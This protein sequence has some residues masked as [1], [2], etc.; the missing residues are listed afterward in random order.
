MTIEE[1]LKDYILMKNRSVRE[2]AMKIGM[3][4]S[5]IN[6]IFKRG[7]ENSSVTT[8]I[9]ICRGLGISTDELAEGRITPVGLPSLDPVKL[10]DIFGTAKQAII[11]ADAITLDGEVLSA[12]DI[13]AV[14]R[15]LDVIMEVQKNYTAFNKKEGE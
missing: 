8:V 5:T 10:E 14:I 6:M 11:N 13:D 7:I 12:S 9:R 4:V 15:S 1:R 2:F 3:P